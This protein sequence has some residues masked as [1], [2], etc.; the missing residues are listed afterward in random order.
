MKRITV[1]AAAIIV[2]TLG[3]ARTAN[4]GAQQAPVSTPSDVTLLPTN[5]P[6]LS[7]DPVQLWMIPSRAETTRTAA[8]NAFASAVRLEVDGNYAKALPVFSEPLLRDTPLGDYV[9][10]YRG[11]AERAVGRAADSRRTF[12]ALAAASPQ[13][14]LAEA[15]PLG[16][17]AADEVLGDAASALAIYE[18]LSAQKISALDDVLMRLG[19]AARSTGDLDKALAAFSRVYYGMPFSDLASSA[20]AEL[21]MLPNR[22]PLVA[23]TTR[24]KLELGRAEQL[25]SGKRYTPARSAFEGLQGA[26]Q[27]DD[28]EL[29]NLRLAETDYFLKRSR[30]ARDALRPYVENA[31]RQGEALFFYAVSLYDLGDRDE[32]LRVI[33]RVADEFPTQSWSEEALNN[34]A[35]YYILQDEDDQA[36]ETFR[37]MY[38]RFPTGRYAERAAWKIG[39]A[40]YRNRNYEDAVRAFEGGAA[41]F[42]RSDYRPAWLYWAGRAH[43][44]LNEPDVAKARYTLTA[45]DYLN[46]YYGRLA[47]KRLDGHAPDRPL[48]VDTP[49]QP[50]LGTSATGVILTSAAPSAGG[51]D[52][53]ESDPAAPTA[54]LPPN[55]E[56]VRKLLGLGLYDQALDELHYAQKAWG[57]SPPIEATIAWIDQKQGQTETGMRKLT[58]YRAGMN[59]MKRAYPQYLAAGGERLPAEMLRVIFPLSYWDLIQKYSALHHLD[60][61]LVAAL[62]A[63][64]STFVA[65]VQSPAKAVGLMQLMAPTARQYAK[66]MKIRYSPRILTNPEMSIKI[67]TTYLA[68]TLSAFGELHLVLATYNAG[69]RPVRRWMAEREGQGL[70]QEEFIDDIPYPETQNYVKKILGTAEDYRRLY[71]GDASA[72]VNTASAAASEPKRKAPAA[73]AKKRPAP[74]PKRRPRTRR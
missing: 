22:G 61:Y 72:D 64:E 44:A 48:V 33:R 26:A 6:R 38:A 47:V 27:G 66:Q 49:R 13:G 10:Y 21:E 69:E 31:S 62:M 59:A 8:L 39:W 24:F 71:G 9:V 60:P 70:S 74:K 25:F 58:L 52:V 37:E 3:P 28:R 40:A 56:L 67:G 36:D 68:D 46:S 34:L 20:G 14:Y 5:H 18:R 35:T 2:L 23:G 55:H 12:Q 16:E 57:D 19:R 65:D 30:N 54:A 51:V 17:A 4:L 11:L 50:P 7:A 41:R 29:V 45:T 42:P 53:P 1:C 63:Q 32:Y 15:A 43:E 73:P